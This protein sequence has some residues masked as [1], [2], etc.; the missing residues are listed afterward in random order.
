MIL[1]V[2]RRYPLT[3]FTLEKMMNNA[4][5]EVKEESEVSLE[6]L[7]FEVILNGDS[8]ILTRVIKGVVQPVA[9]TTAEQRLVRKNALKARAIEKR[10]GGNKETKKV[11][12][13]LFKQQYENFTGLS[14][15]SLD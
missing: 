3:R 12:K 14:S 9:P 5:L 13:T 8:P 7:K 11:H 15:E 6:L 4:R 1:L 10:F 2:E